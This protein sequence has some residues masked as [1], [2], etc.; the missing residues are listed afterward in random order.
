M[1]R[2]AR[3][4]VAYPGLKSDIVSL[5]LVRSVAV[6]DRRVHGSLMLASARREVPDLLR[7]A[8]RSTLKEAGAVRTEVQIL[9]PDRRLP[10]R[11][12]WTDRGRLTG[13]RRVLAVG[14]GKGGVGKSTVAVNLALALRAE[15][16]RVGARRWRTATPGYHPSRTGRRGPPPWRSG[17][18]P[19]VFATR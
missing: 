12:P 1:V 13:V 18:S 10:V 5:G 7:A 16:F 19:A 4:E 8:I 15:G 2:A 11:D 17:R 3:S 6:R 14:A 9:A